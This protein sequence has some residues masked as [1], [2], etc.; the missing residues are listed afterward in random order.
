MLGSICARMRPL[1]GQFREFR[2]VAGQVYKD[3]QVEITGLTKRRVLKQAALPGAAA[4]SPRLR[5][6]PFY[7]ST[8]HHGVK[9]F[10]S[11][12]RMLM[13]VHYGDAAREYKALTEDVAIW[14]VAAER[15]VELRGKDAF[16]LAQLL[17]CRDLT[18]VTNK[19][20]VY[21]IMCDDE[22][23]VINDPVLIKHSDDR[24]WL[25]IADSDVLLWAKGLAIG[26]GLDVKVS[27]PD[28]SPLALQGPK[29][30]DLVADLFGAD[31][32][33]GMKHFEYRHGPETRLR[34]MPILLARSGWSPEH[35]YELYLQDGRR[36][37]ELW[38]LIWEAGQ[39]YNIQPGCPNQQRRVEAGMLSFGGDTL[40][41]TNA[42]ELG[43]S[44]KFCDPFGKYDFIGKEALQKIATEGTRY[45]FGGIYFNERPPFGTDD[46]RGRHLKVWY[47]G[48]DQSDDPKD[49]IPYLKRCGTLTAQS[50]SPKF[51]RNLGIGFFLTDLPPH[52]PI[53]VEMANGSFVRGHTTKLPFRPSLRRTLSTTIV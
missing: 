40:P 51:K 36:G 13:P 24:Y 23:I 28:V 38:S 29:S 10:T 35:G 19:I 44:K 22:G 39:K 7:E 32:V 26:R 30:K 27:E 12:N 47:G 41:R 43:L 34:G 9:E 14:D 37:N 17:T 2:T 25:S 6:S 1:E 42:L 20:C 4:M 52:A 48:P 50:Y 46:W 15:Q 11:Y 33:E 21:A 53:R 31:V 16:K 5:K 18:N 45:T 49:F 3:K 8:L